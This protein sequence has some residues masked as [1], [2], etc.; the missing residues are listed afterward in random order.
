MAV[1]IGVTSISLEENGQI[2]V[3]FESDVRQFDNL[4]ALVDYCG[5]VDSVANIVMVEKMLLRWWL[6]RDSEALSPG[7]VVGKSITF[8]LSQPLMI[9]VA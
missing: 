9:D 6:L 3:N 1:S 5:D 7:I 4:A 2:N 8:D